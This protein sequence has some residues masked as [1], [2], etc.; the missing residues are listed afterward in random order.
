MPGW[1]CGVL[2]QHRRATI[3]GSQSLS[4]N[5]E[6]IECFIVQSE[7]EGF[8]QKSDGATRETILIDKLRFVVWQHDELMWVNNGMQYHVRIDV[9]NV[10]LDRTLR[11][12]MFTFRPPKGSKLLPVH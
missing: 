6:Q 5:G 2:D 12:G 9:T 8:A 1:S 7:G 3:T 10:K 11:F 4:V